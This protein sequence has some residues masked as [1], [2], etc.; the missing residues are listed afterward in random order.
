MSSPKDNDW[1]FST[2]YCPQ[3]G[4]ENIRHVPHPDE[5]ECLDCGICFDVIIYEK[6]AEEQ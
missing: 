6:E 5:F 4:G 3:C 1:K 2:S